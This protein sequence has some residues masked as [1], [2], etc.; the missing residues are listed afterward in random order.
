MNLPAHLTP[1]LITAG[2]GLVLIWIFRWGWRRRTRRPRVNRG[3]DLVVDV[4]ALDD[5]GP[6]ADGPRVEFYGTHVRLAV[7]VVAPG[8]RG[9]ELPP[10]EMFPGLLEQLVP[11]MSAVLTHHKPLL[12]PW[13]TQLSS[14]GFA[15]AFFNHVALPGA[16]GR[17]TRWCSLAGKLAVGDRVFLVGLVFCAAMP[18]SLS[19][20][21]VEHEGQWLD[22]LRIRSA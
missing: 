2:I 7:V 17:G 13:P 21:T 6:S 19:Q 10:H 18:N 3:H 8:G 16:R 14:H 12:R 4:S 11:G 22:V 5:H 20:L 15:Q 1:W 9:G